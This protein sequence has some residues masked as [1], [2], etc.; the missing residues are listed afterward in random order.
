MKVGIDGILLG[1]WGRLEEANRILDVGTGTGLLALMAAQRS[2]A[3]IDA[4]ELDPG[5]AAEAGFNF[6]ASPWAGRLRLRKG[7][8]RQL[9]LTDSYDHIL[10][11]PPFFEQG[12]PAAGTSR[13]QARHANSL[14]LDE[15]LRKS[16]CLLTP[17]GKISLIL[18]AR[19]EQRLRLLV[20][21]NRLYISRF[22][23]VFPD[24]GKAA[25]RILVELTD[26]EEET[27]AKDIFI[28]EPGSKAYTD[29]YREL[30]R[31]F[32]LAF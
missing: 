5:A 7:D 20:R 18:P 10:S 4:L 3:R 30:T 28:R 12:T 1:A 27:T 21:E 8:F 13:T 24:G 9:E 22:Y 2:E 11:N 14:P 32:Y 25:H 29:Q 26:R 16:S 15:L 19:T 6:Q 23:K 17:G 31:D